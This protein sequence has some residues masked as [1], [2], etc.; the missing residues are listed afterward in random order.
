LLLA[1]EDVV[2]RGE[3]VMDPDTLEDAPEDWLTEALKDPDEM[4]APGT[5]ELEELELGTCDVD[6]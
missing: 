2:T 4:L 3:T 5:R 6:E 1:V